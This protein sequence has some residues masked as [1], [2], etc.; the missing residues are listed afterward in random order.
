MK[1]TRVIL[2]TVIALVILMLTSAPPASAQC[3]YGCCNPLLLPFA[4]VG[5]AVGTA[6]AIVTAPFRPFYYAPAYG[7]APPAPV[8]YRPAGSYYYHRAWIP[9]HYTPYGAWVP[10]HWLY[11]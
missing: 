3:D 8:Y 4:V 5:A 2:F 6:A 10:G 9:G 1:K 7:P 11:R